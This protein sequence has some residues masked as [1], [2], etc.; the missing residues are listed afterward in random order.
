MDRYHKLS[1]EDLQDCI[2]AREFLAKE[3][4]SLYNVFSALGSAEDINH[5]TFRSHPHCADGIKTM[6]L[7][8]HNSTFTEGR[9]ALDPLNSWISSYGDHA[10]TPLCVRCIRTLRRL[11]NERQKMAWATLYKMFCPPSVR[12][13]A[14]LDNSSEGHPLI[15]ICLSQF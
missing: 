11:V 5:D 8:A 14:V 6:I 2:K 13:L 12:L 15:P 1:F 3:N 9:D 10:G 4:A 7:D